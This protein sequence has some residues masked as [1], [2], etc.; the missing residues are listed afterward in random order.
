VKG[1]VNQCS[2]LSNSTS[3]LSS[4]NTIFDRT[5]VLNVYLNGNWIYQNRGGYDKGFCSRGTNDENDSIYTDRT[6]CHMGEPMLTRRIID[7]PAVKLNKGP[8]AIAIEVITNTDVYH[9]GAFYEVEFTIVDS[10]HH[11][12]ITDSKSNSAPLSVTADILSN[13][14]IEKVSSRK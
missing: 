3:Q 12:T 6:K 13:N 5:D 1:I 14:S 11:D 4:Y 7:G 9:V 2:F 10:T 8:N